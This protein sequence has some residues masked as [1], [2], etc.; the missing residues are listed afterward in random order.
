MSKGGPRSLDPV[1]GVMPKAAQARARRALK[2][3]DKLPMSRQFGTATG[4]AMARA[5]AAG[6][7]V[8][9]RKVSHFFPRW[10]RRIVAREREGLTPMDNKIVGASDLWGGPAGDV[11]SVRAVKPDELKAVQAMYRKKRR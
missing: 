9:M 5:M 7:E 6:K 3:L 10:R 11:A 8:D 4:L 1:W 2:A